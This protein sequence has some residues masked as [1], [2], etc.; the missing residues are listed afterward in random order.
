[1]VAIPVVFPAVTFPLAST[2]AMPLLLEVQ[3]TPE[4]GFDFFPPTVVATASRV[5]LSPT[6]RMTFV[7]VNV[8]E[9]VEFSE[10]KKPSQ[11]ARKSTPVRVRTNM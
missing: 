8:T 1:M 3:V 10:T 4:L 2:A 11:P 7:G 6:L 9:L 5:T